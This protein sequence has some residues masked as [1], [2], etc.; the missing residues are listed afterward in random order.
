MVCAIASFIACS[1]NAAITTLDFTELPFQPVDGLSYMGVTFGFRIG[2]TPSADANYNSG[3]PGSVVFVQDP[4]LEGNAAGTLTLIFDKPTDLL[5][6][7]VALS[8]NS[9]ATPGFVVRLFD[10]SLVLVGVYPV[11]TS[12]LLSFTEGQ[13]TYSGAPIIGATIGFNNQAASRFAFDNLTFN[14]I[15]APGAILLSSIGLGVVSWLRRRRT[16]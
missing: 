13:F 15:P 1:A 8:S 7:G 10:P 3:G 2:A 11:N 9:D 6:F 12:P 4:S 16:L 5:E 14:P